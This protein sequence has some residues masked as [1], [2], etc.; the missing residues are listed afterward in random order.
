[1]PMSK[2][3][4][5]EALRAQREVWRR[6]GRAVAFTNG[7]FDLLHIGH[8]RYL[9]EARGLAGALIVALNSDASVRA[10][11]GPSRPLVPQ[12]ERAELLAAL[13]CVDRLVIF[14][15]PTA[16][17]LVSLLQP[18]VYVKGG[19][20]A[21]AGAAPAERVEITSVEQLSK[22]LP[23][24][25]VALSCGSRVVLVPYQQGY[26]TTELIERILRTAGG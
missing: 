17:D 23:E 4:R 1:M 19:D 5:L 11:K 22:P 21:R 7:V 14:D 3:V 6:E 25:P 13:E 12:A 16:S 2:I 24:A 9:Q 26:S 10:L 15:S 8:V 20:Y 18:E